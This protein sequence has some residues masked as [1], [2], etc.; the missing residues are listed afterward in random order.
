M[1]G[2]SSAQPV[3]APLHLAPEG[4]APPSAALGHLPKG[5]DLGL[6]LANIEMMVREIYGALF[7]PSPV[8]GPRS[9]ARDKG[10][11]SLKPYDPARYTDAIIEARRGNFKAIQDYLKK[12]EPRPGAGNAG[13]K[14]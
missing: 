10:A 14:R 3:V 8:P 13:G 2:E 9:G 11:L 4:G 12:Y 6:R 5:E 7:G 1:K